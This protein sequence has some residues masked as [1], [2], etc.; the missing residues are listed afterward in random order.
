MPET[1]RSSEYKF[2]D[3]GVENLA[4]KPNTADIGAYHTAIL[5]LFPKRQPEQGI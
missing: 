3:F 2:R 1:I 5:F 4:L